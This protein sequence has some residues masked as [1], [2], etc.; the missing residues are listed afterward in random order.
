MLIQFNS[1]CIRKFY[2]FCV[3]LVCVVSSEAVL[4]AEWSIEPSVSIRE[5]Y[6]DNIRFTP[7]AHPSVW[8]S[9]LSP[10]VKLSSKTEVS[11]VS[12]LVQVNINRFTGD[13]GLNQNDRVF[14]LFTSLQSERNLWGVDVSY[15]QDSTSESEQAKTGVV[16]ART[17]RSLLSI[18]PSW[19]R[20]L[21]ELVSLKLDYGFQEVKYEAPSNQNDYTHHQV[22][23]VLQYQLS[24]RDQLSLT[25]SYSLTNL[26]PIISQFPEFMEVD[27]PPFG[28]VPIPWGGTDT[29]DYKSSVRSLQMKFDHTFSETL[30]GNLSVGWNIVNTDITHTCNGYLGVQYSYLNGYNGTSCS[31]FAEHP[32]VTFNSKTEGTGSS[33]NV[34]LEKTFDTGKA[35][36]FASRE[37]NPSG[38][39]LVVTDKLGV[40]LAKSFREDF[41]GSV[42]AT[43]YRTKFISMASPGSRYYTFEPKLNWRLTEWW[44]FDAG[45]RYS[46]VE[47]ENVPTAITANMV[48]FNLAHNWPKKAISR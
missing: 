9:S 20:S 33:F 35:S 39:G 15:M 16:Q 42:D 31:G 40:S 21:T 17:R 25:A 34:S 48:Y 4:S 26:A 44:T 37:T 24:E 12:G 1:S 6:H 47:Y 38:N 7:L 14:R 18:N 28:L 43:S 10:S 36:G 45:Y 13:P 11:E 41:T 32:L 8:E 29:I 46:R 5:A 19:T 23:T 3:V 22:G 27:F 2:Q 30:Q